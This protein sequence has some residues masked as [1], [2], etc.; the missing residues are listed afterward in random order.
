MQ[1][2]TNEPVYRLVVAAVFM[3][4]GFGGGVFFTTHDYVIGAL[5]LGFGALLA[6]TS[7]RL[8]RSR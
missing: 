5:F 7:P 8:I 4:L 3:L 1:P 2:Q 6:L